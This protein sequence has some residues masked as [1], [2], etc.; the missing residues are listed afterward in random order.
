M[1]LELR[2]EKR[3]IR[4]AQQNIGWFAAHL[5]RSGI[6]NT[7]L[8]TKLAGITVYSV[9][10]SVVLTKR[11]NTNKSFCFIELLLLKKATTHA[12]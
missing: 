3:I 7:Q 8:S 1:L 12:L 9:A 5:Q 10:G 11:A 4:Q 6:I 2:K